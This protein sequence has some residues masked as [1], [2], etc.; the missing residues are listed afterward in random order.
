M[1]PVIAISEVGVATPH[2]TLDI[3]TGR[4]CVF[5]VGFKSAEARTHF[6]QRGMNILG[7]SDEILFWHGV[8]PAPVDSFEEAMRIATT[9]RAN[10][11]SVIGQLGVPPD[12]KI[13]F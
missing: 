3:H 9:A 10:P 4:Y 6:L 7:I 13:F 5:V 1:F 12:T 2:G 11:A 8:P